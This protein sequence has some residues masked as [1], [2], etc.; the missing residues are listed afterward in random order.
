MDNLRKTKGFEVVLSALCLQRS[1]EA[2]FQLSCLQVSCDVMK[3][4]LGRYTR[5]GRL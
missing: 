5:F 3:G 2:A 1:S 4:Q